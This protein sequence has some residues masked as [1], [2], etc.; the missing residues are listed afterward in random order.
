MAK[1]AQKYGKLLE[2]MR[3]KHLTLKNRIVKS[4]QWLILC[5]P[6][7][8]VGERLIGF[9]QAIARGGCGLVTVEESIVDHPLGA[10]N[11]PHLR[12]DDDRFIPGLSRLAAAIHRRDV[13]AFVQI[14]HAGPA[15]NP[16]VSGM[17]PVAPSRLDP[18]AEPLFAVAKEL[19]VSEIKELVEKYAQAALRVKKAGFDG[20]EMH[21]AHYA[22]VNA[23]LSRVQNKR[24]D[25]YGCQSL[26]TRGRFSTEILRRVRELC[27]PEFV[28]GVRMSAKEWG[29]ELGTTNE[30]AVQFART[31]EKAG[32]DYLQ[33]SAYGYGPFFL[34]ALPDIVLY[35]EVFDV[36]KPFTDRIRDGALIPEA[37]AIRKAVSIPVSGVGRLE[38][39]SAERALEQGDVDLVCFGRRLMADPEMPRKLAEGREKE[40]RPCLGCS[41]CLHIM[42]MNQPVQCRMNAF[43]GNETTMAVTPAQKK[44]KVMVVGAGPAGLEAARVAAE[45]GH[46]VTLYERAPELGGLLPMA[47]FIKGKELDDLTE[48][49]TYFRDELKRLK[50][51]VHLGKEVDPALVE[52]V[53]PDAVILA[54][55]GTPIDP[56]IPGMNLPNVVT[57]EALKS[58]AKEFVRYLGPRLM[59]RLTKI[60]LP[61]G[62]RVIVVGGDLAGLEAAE[63]LAKRG[64]EVTVVEQA[65]QIGEGMLIQWFLKLGP[66]M[67]AKKIQAYAGVKFEE[68]TAKGMTITT[69]EG[70]RKTLAADAVMVV[71]RYRKNTRLHD[72]LKGKVPA[73]HLIGD[74]KSDTSGYILGAIHDGARVGLTI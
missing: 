38:P 2:P 61:V 41:Q 53:K 25:E 37:A 55:G 9:Y 66:W 45:R 56:G 23:F 10:S 28:V 50:V 70:E 17:Q 16:Q 35:P 7:G 24:Q 33:A 21:M 1:K 6:D 11:V 60:Y 31:F 22:L 32:A 14:T 12:L 39:E 52:R 34:C 13:P 59:S 63:F 26:E 54:P 44:K 57:T 65:D 74:A 5:E 64:K 69:K 47:S 48:A 73:L 71:S 20:V 46:D 49:I 72:A 51:R 8:S 29:H 40:I 30:E 27:G 43:M 67:Q 58:Q 15:H 19:T 18:P 3:L 68:I 4:A 62:K 36:T 42:F